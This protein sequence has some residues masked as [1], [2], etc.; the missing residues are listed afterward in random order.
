[1]SAASRSLRGLLVAAAFLLA[2]GT[3]SAD[4]LWSWSFGSE[5][6]TFVTNG[7]LADINGPFDF[8]IQSFFVTSSLDDEDI[9]ATYAG[10]DLPQGFLWDGSQPTEFYR[11]GGVFTNGANFFNADTGHF[12]TLV[13]ANLTSTFKTGGKE[14][15][16]SGALTIVPLV[17]TNVQV[18][19]LSPGMLG[20]LGMLVAGA[21]FRILR[22]AS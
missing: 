9:G 13:P 5:A 22:A 6:G 10:Q 11:A 17:N 1:M 8:T 12:F 4:L 16:D 19:A 15:L 3:A 18:P 7:T 14:L 21:A 2:V 20:I